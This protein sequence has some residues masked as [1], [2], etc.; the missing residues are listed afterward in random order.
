MRKITGVP[1]LVV[2]RILDAATA[3]HALTVDGVDLVGI[4][5]AVIADPEMPRK[6]AAAR[7]PRLCISLNE[8][9]I[10]RLYQGLP[11]WCSINPGI[12]D[13]ELDQ[14]PASS[15]GPSNSPRPRPDY[16]SCRSATR[17]PHEPCSTPSPKEHGR[18]PPGNDMIGRSGVLRPL[19]PIGVD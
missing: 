2:G 11:M 10:G 5:R 9:C 15:P 4:N 13:P 14:P 16:T 7:T 3:E 1:V 6:Y 19:R 8:E 17:S 18:A 12:R